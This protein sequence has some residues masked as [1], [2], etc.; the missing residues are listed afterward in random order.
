MCKGG[1]NMKSVSEQR[2][3]IIG[4]K[5]EMPKAKD[6]PDGTIYENLTDGTVNVAYHGTWYEK[7]NDV[8][9]TEVNENIA[10]RL[11]FLRIESSVDDNGHYKISVPLDFVKSGELYYGIICVKNSNIPEL[12]AVTIVSH[13][14]RTF[15]L[16]DTP[17]SPSANFS[18]QFN[19]STKIV[20]LRNNG[21]T[22]EFYLDIFNY[23]Y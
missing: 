4:L 14:I 10:K 23:P 11:S 8:D 21:N 16:T 5:S 7:K 19:Q 13:D 15:K 20:T 18:R 1:G 9:L 22:D 3:R 17:I 12:F 6:V 2:E